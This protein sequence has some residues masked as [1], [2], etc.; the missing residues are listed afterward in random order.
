M[1]GLADMQYMLT[2][3]TNVEGLTVRVRFYLLAGLRNTNHRLVVVPS[4][5]SLKVGFLIV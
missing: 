4:R 3:S 2:G 5:P 1:S